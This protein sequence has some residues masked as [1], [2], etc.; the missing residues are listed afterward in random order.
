MLVARDRRVAHGDAASGRARR[1]A[2]TDARSRC[3]RG[4]ATLDRELTPLEASVLGDVRARR[5][6]ASSGC[7]RSLNAG[8]RCA[9]VAV[10]LL[11]T[12][13]LLP[14][15]SRSSRRCA[16]ARQ[17]FDHAVSGTQRR[18]LGLE[19]RAPRTL[20]LSPRVERA[21][22]HRARRAARDRRA[23]SCAACMRA[24]A[25]ALLAQRRATT[26]AAASRSTS[27]CGCAR[28]TGDRRW[29]RTRGRSVRDARR[30][31]LRMAGSLTDIS[32]R[33]QAE[34]RRCSRRRERAQVTLASIADAVITVDRPG[35]HRVPEPGGGAAHRLARRRRARPCRSPTCSRCVTR[36]TGAPMRR[37]GRARALR[38]GATVKSE[39]NVALC[40]RDGGAD[41]D[42]LQR[43]ADPR[44]ARAHRRRRARVPRHEPRAPVRERGWRTSRATTR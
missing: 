29:F 16:R 24:T 3:S 23:A 20:Y 11:R 13:R 15:R 14:R 42:R 6:A 10:A 8:S 27:S 12:R 32:D 18:H 25:L 35:P 4:C 40:R 26:C 2:P 44:P 7:S 31:P 30:R 28:T 9:L 1:C 39:G 19:S 41:R 38:D 22:R 5:R 33:K 21:A 34:A 37:S 36:A 17:R 43:R